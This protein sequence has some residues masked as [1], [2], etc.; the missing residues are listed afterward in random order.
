MR[1]ASP[2]ALAAL[3]LALALA[4]RVASAQTNSNSSASAVSYTQTNNKV[5]SD[6]NCNS[7]CTTWTA[8]VG[9]CS[10]GTSDGKW[11][12][13]ITTAVD[14]NTAV[15]QLYQDSA[16]S[17]V[18]APGNLIAGAAITMKLDDTCHSF[19]MLGGL[20]TGS[21]KASKVAPLPGWAIAVIVIFGVLLPLACVGGCIWTCCC[22]NRA[23][24]MTSPPPLA[25]PMVIAPG[26]DLP[27]G[28][29][30]PS[31]QQQ[32]QWQGAPQQ[33][34][35][36]PAGF[37]PQQQFYPVP[38]Q[39]QWAP[40]PQQQPFAAQYSPYAQPQQFAP[41]PGGQAPAYPQ[42]PAQQAPYGYAPPP[43][44]TQQQAQWQP[45]MNV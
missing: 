24:T 45:K 41:A 19:S 34:Q 21:Y 30:A 11:V 9:K 1:R 22:R 17:R 25:S 10:P 36:Y 43:P 33:Q 37:V 14:D 15:L 16:A 5:C 32:Q 40:Q 39:G 7:G 8:D 31:A 29:S 38:Q 13:S 3:W 26:Q 20:S 35:Q 18:C 44:Q 42:L 12:S 27:A 2:R 23:V 28:Y 4:A 6:A